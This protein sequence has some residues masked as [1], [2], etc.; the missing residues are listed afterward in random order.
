MTTHI[1][2]NQVQRTVK[3]DDV[4]LFSC[5]DADEKLFHGLSP[6]YAG[7]ARRMAKTPELQEHK[8]KIFDLKY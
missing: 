1:C 2:W 6:I 8:S 7:K 3:K 4:V 5:N